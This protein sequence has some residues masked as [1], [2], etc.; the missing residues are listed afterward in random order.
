MEANK[1]VFNDEFVSMRER[2]VMQLLQS[3]GYERTTSE[4]VGA[5][6]TIEDYIL[7]KDSPDV[8]PKTL[9]NEGV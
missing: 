9:K 7:G 3:M 2:I 8:D 4:I 5:A 1:I 6:K